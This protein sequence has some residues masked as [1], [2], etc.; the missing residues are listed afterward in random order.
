M[1]LPV[2][3]I[4]IS[5]ISTV[6]VA[7]ASCGSETPVEKLYNHSTEITSQPARWASSLPTLN[8]VPDSASYLMGYIY[9]TRLNMM[10]SSGRL[11]ELDNIDREE[12]DKGIAMALDADSTQLGLLYGIMIGLELRGNMNAISS[13][14]DLKWNTDLT[15]KGFY[16]GLNGTIPQALPVQLVEEQLNR[17]LRPFFVPDDYP[18]M[19]D[20]SE[21]V[22]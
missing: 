4:L 5:I 13:D 1:K 22:K 19:E 16:Q 8:S 11:A 15:Y 21:D 6:A 3:I 9:G 17:L 20:E 7:A 18:V 14:I 12:F 10:L 2:K